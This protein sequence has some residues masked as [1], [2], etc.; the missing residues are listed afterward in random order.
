MKFPGIKTSTN[1]V[2]SFI[3]RHHSK[4]TLNRM[5]SD[6]T[7]CDS[8]RVHWVLLSCILYLSFQINTNAVCRIPSFCNPVYVRGISKC[9]YFRSCALSNFLSCRSRPRSKRTMSAVEYLERCLTSLVFTAGLRLLMLQNYFCK[10][11]A[12][13][14]SFS[15]DLKLRSA[16]IDKRIQFCLD[17]VPLSFLFKI[18]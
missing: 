12:F 5:L 11:Q 2:F 13:L 1:N 8:L 16:L 15:S 6:I 4:M 9:F 18:V 17:L 14:T 7:T 10:Y 3:F